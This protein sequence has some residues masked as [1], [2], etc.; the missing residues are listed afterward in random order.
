MLDSVL[1]FLYLRRWAV[2]KADG[3]ESEFVTTNR[4][5][6]LTFN[7]PMKV[8]PLYRRSPGFGLPNT[9]VF[10][11]LTRQAML[12]GRFDRT[13][14]ARQ[15]GKSHVAALN[16]H[17]ITHSY[18]KIFSRRKE[19]LYLNPFDQSVHQ[20]GLLLERAASWREQTERR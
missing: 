5:V 11:P 2:L 7:D 19:F 17:M 12:V 6:T 4:P 8:P 3:L 10:F 9:E 20:D 14:T 1:Q 15:I 18:G 16:S 13:V